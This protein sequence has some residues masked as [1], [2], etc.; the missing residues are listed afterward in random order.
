MA[1]ASPPRP[2]PA[3]EGSR[4]EQQKTEGLGV[5][6]D[7]AIKI[8]RN[9]EKITGSVSAI[10]DTLAQEIAKDPKAFFLNQSSDADA[11]VAALKAKTEGGPGVSGGDVVGGLGWSDVV[12]TIKA[13]EG[14]LKDEKNFVME[15][16]RLIF[17]GCSG[18]G[19]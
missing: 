17:C 5:L 13:L 14:F 4:L 12:D 16:L 8:T 15:I 11:L 2:P 3:E 9:D 18:K 19:W 1:E 10:V 6:L 7:L